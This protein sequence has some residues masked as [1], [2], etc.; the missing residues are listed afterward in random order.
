MQHLGYDLKHQRT[1]AVAVVSLDKQANVRLMT[2]SNYQAFQAG[3]RFSSYGGKATRSPVRLSIPSTGY[4]FVVVDLGGLNGRVRAGVTVQPPPPGMLPPLRERSPIRDVQVR[5]PIE[6]EGDTFGGQT[7]DVFIS[8]ASEDKAS[9]ALPLRDALVESG[10][11]VWLD[12]SEMRLGDSLRRK[13][14]HDLTA[15]QVRGYSPSLAD[16]VALHTGRA[17]IEEMAEEIAT[18]VKGKAE[19]DVA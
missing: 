17:S 19:D 15:E 13:I 16:K 4:W 6:P 7:W 18:V 10:V 12:K 8:H 2:A 1:G 3:R 11:T 9:V 14:W 5:E